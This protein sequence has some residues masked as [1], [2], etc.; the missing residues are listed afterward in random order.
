MERDRSDLEGTGD[1]RHPNDCLER[2]DGP[3][4]RSD[5]GDL[6]TFGKGRDK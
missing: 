2:E 4:V 1:S 3:N 6:G 5:L